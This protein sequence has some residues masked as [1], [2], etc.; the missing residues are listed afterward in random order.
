[1]T[2]VNT[3]NRYYCVHCKKVVTMNSDKQWVGSWCEDYD[4]YV[5]LILIEVGQPKQK[6]TLPGHVDK[7]VSKFGVEILDDDG[8]PF[9]SVP[10]DGSFK[11][12]LFKNEA[13]AKTLLD[14]IKKKHPDWS[15][16]VVTVDY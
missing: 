4:R 5:H 1:M 11:P 16:K 3:K 13:D 10:S 9:L 15:A 14:A 7:I 8:D 2:W 6:T 12:Q